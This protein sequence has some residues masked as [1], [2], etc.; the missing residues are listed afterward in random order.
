MASKSPAQ[1]KAEIDAIQAEVREAGTHPDKA[2]KVRD[3]LAQSAAALK[4][5]GG[6]SSV[7]PHPNQEKLDEQKGKK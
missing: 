4:Q 1:R 5:P 7:V 6:D 2:N 3:I